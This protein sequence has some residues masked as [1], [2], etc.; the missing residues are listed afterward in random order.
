MIIIINS[1][2]SG[3]ARINS[4]RILD[5]FLPRIGRR[6][7]SG[8]IT[9]QGLRRLKETLAKKVTTNSSICCQKVSG[10]NNLTVLWFLGNRKKFDTKGNCSVSESS[11][12]VL[13]ERS[14]S[15]V[16]NLTRASSELAA[17]FHDLGKATHW[18]Q[19]KLAKARVISDPIR[20]ELVSYMILRAMLKLADGDEAKWLSKLADRENVGKYICESYDHAFSHAHEM[21]VHNLANNKLPSL[22][23]AIEQ[24][25]KNSGK[26]VGIDFYPDANLPKF[27]L[28]SLMVLTHHRLPEGYIDT[29]SKQ[30]RMS[31]QNMK[32]FWDD[33][34]SS[35]KGSNFTKAVDEML[36]HPPKKIG[37]WED[38]EYLDAVSY[39]SQRLIDAVCSDNFHLDV[40]MAAIYGR[41]SLILGDHK[42]SQVG[43]TK[44]PKEGDKADLR[45]IYANTNRNKGNVLAEP[46]SS[47][48]RRVQKETSNALDNVFITKNDFPV[49]EH[50]EIPDAIRSPRI[51]L[52]TPYNWQHEAAKETKSA[53]KATPEGSGFFGVLMAG[54]GSGKTRMAP[55]LMSA[56][57]PHGLR[58]NVCT[59]MRS[60]TLQGGREYHDDMHFRKEDISVVIGDELTSELFNLERSTN[61]GTDAE[62]PDQAIVV[63]PDG[64]SSDHILPKST[65]RLLGVDA[66]SS[67]S[68]LLASPILVSTI[69]TLMSA[70]DATRGRHVVKALRLASSDLVIDEIDGY[71][72]EDL[73]AIS[74]LVY[75]AAAFGRKVIISSATVSPE[76]SKS[77]WY[78]YK[79]GWAVHC[80]AIGNQLPVLTGWY[81]EVCAPLCDIIPDT[82]TFIRSHG[83]FV[84]TIL[85]GLDLKPVLRKTKIA[86]VGNPKDIKE[87]F[88]RITDEIVN[89]HRHHH[90]VDEKSGKNLSLGVVRWNNVAPSMLHSRFLL[91]RACSDDHDIF[92]VPYNGTL[93]PAVRYHVETALNKML[94]RKPRNGNDPVLSND[95]VRNVLDNRTSAKNV[96]ILVVTTSIEEVGRDHDFDFAIVEPGSLR[97]LIQMG[98]RV[99][100]HR[101]TATDYPNI[102]IMERS[103]KELLSMW[104]EDFETKNG[105]FSYPGIETPIKLLDTTEKPKDFAE[106][107]KLSSHL[108]TD[109]YDFAALSERLDARDAIAITPSVMS[110]LGVKERELTRSYLEDGLAPD[111]QLSV[112]DYVRDEMALLS[113]H[114]PKNRKFRRTDS[115]DIPYTLKDDEKWYVLDP[116]LNTGTN[117]TI[118]KMVSTFKLENKERLLLQLGSVSELTAQL[119]AN[120]WNGDDEVPS[121][122]RNSLSTILR[123]IRVSR[124][125]IKEI[126]SKINTTSFYFN[127]NL[128]MVEQHKWLT[129]LI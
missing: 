14:V 54:T 16:E 129:Q 21:T 90:V 32:H 2:C 116:D 63:T 24:S 106:K 10:T 23:V 113:N 122:K 40:R 61:I 100:R 99:R 86:E 105:Y 6:C 118:N 127:A 60:L 36:S 77:L 67:N 25:H 27:S 98:G 41:T 84:G 46:L 35:K 82:D 7:W 1:E 94:K 108:A 125:E 12:N 18:F 39:V 69:D 92:V 3:N 81:S 126:T 73:V 88:D 114:H 123:P 58:M 42:G 70:A 103:F 47:H 19:N 75:L 112:N 102:A 59:G 97:G 64:T 57:S 119:C 11:K 117:N 52:N 65:A 5:D 107:T 28:V 4:Q 45:L 79:E 128:G 83:A 78:A 31:F 20:H 96:I 101:Q 49:I 87:F 89:M 120:L 111:E 93:L 30:V 37:V 80:H 72:N 104:G 29:K 74:R 50:S 66:T 110:V 91:D 43:N 51:A 53:F 44:F 15:S 9:E 71:G 17:L 124:K 68:T 55:I 13:I 22:A 95:I 8:R 33:S 38:K 26:H 56:L 85:T 34:G 121:W 109:L 48:L 62:E 76:I 115:F